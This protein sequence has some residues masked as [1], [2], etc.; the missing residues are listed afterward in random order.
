MLS[1]CWHCI[2]KGLLLLIA[3]NGSPVLIRKVLGTRPLKPIDNGYNLSDG[4]RLFGNTKTWPGLLSSLFFTTVIAFIFGINLLTGF[5][6]AMLTMT[7]DI[8]TSFIKRRLGKQDSSR[9]RGLDTLP[10]S[11]LPLWLLSDA[12]GL[13]LIDIAITAGLFFLCEEFISPILYKIHIRNQPY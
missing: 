7:G 4:Y 5:F 11:L 2:F 1:F 8:L 3:A 6:F 10:E 9:A 13:N 12:L